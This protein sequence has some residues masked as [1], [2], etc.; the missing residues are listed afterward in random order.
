MDRYTLHFSIRLFIE[1]SE[2]GRANFLWSNQE[3][4][5]LYPMI[6]S[7]PHIQ[8]TRWIKEKKNSEIVLGD[9]T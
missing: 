6:N 2:N 7:F 8:K 5:I 4:P 1:F 9:R 3:K